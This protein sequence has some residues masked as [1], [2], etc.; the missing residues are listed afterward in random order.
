MHFSP[1][2]RGLQNSGVS[3]LISGNS[4]YD[5]ECVSRAADSLTTQAFLGYY[6]VIFSS[7]RNILPCESRW[8]LYWKV[9]TQ[10]TSRTSNV[11]KLL[12]FL[13]FI[14]YFY[15]SFFILALSV[16]L[17]PCLFFHTLSN[18]GIFPFGFFLNSNF[19]NILLNFVSTVHFPASLFLK[20]LVKFKVES[21]CQSTYS[22]VPPVNC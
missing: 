8:P 5:L 11:F 12:F 15:F 9:K 7:V 6:S 14:F 19:V 18:V 3:G 21:D 20:V 16:W 4:L 22:H 10:L 17:H 1:S 13:F 2:W